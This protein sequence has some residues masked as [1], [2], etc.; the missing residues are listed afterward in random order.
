MCLKVS[1]DPS[2]NATRSGM[3]LGQIDESQLYDQKKPNS[4]DMLFGDNFDFTLD[5]I[6]GLP[7]FD[8][9]RRA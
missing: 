2:Q 5:L 8:L 6:S 7:N 9:A 4:H 1:P 3:Q